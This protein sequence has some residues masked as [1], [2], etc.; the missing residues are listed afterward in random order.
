VAFRHEKIYPRFQLRCATGRCAKRTVQEFA[1]LWL[2]GGAKDQAI[3]Y[4]RPP[5]LIDSAN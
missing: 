2:F 1:E 4:F 5:G 3:E